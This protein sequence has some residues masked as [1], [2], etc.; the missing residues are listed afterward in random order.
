MRDHE[1]CSLL[2]IVVKTPGGTDE[3]CGS[4]DPEG[5]EGNDRHSHPSKTAGWWDRRDLSWF[6]KSAKPE[7]ERCPIALKPSAND[8]G[9]TD[10]GR[11]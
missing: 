5:L 3:A 2:L 11:E 8:V 9:T 4:A 10:L 7:T 6:K 1:R